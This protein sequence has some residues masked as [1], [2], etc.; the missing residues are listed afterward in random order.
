MDNASLVRVS[1]SAV[2]CSAVQYLAQLHGQFLYK[3]L[4]LVEVASYWTEQTYFEFLMPCDILYS[5]VVIA[6]SGAGN[7]VPSFAVN[8]S[9]GTIL[10]STSKHMSRTKKINRKVNEVYYY[11]SY[12]VE[13]YTFKLVL[14][15]CYIH[16]IREEV[17][18]KNI[19][20]ISSIGTA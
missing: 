7:G 17:Y 15:V 18:I 2:A 9:T 5:V 20:D 6:G 13:K 16:F 1:W 10:Y 14:T 4:A 3:P 11:T 19:N 8:G 12:K